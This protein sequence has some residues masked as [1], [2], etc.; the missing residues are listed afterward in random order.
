MPN[1]HMPEFDPYSRRPSECNWVLMYLNVNWLLR[2]DYIC[3]NDYNQISYNDG[4]FHGR[5][6]FV[7]SE[8]YGGETWVLQ[9]SSYFGYGEQQRF[10][11]RPI[12]GTD[13]WLHINQPNETYNCILMPHI[14]QRDSMYLDE[15]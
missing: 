2:P 14:N 4:E 8:H 12:M 6:D 5:T 13:S 15:R 10:V 11:F 9:C 7:D 1:A 3:I